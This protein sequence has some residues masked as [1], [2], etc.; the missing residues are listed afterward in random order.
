MK[1]VEASKRAAVEWN[2]LPSEERVKYIDLAKED[3]K[4]FEKQKNELAE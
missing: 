4:R 2:Q 3:Q 1:L